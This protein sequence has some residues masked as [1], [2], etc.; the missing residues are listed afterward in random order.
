MRDSSTLSASERKIVV[1][2]VDIDMIIGT[3]KDID[4]R[5][6]LYPQI[7]PYCFRRMISSS[8]DWY[9]DIRSIR[10][11]PDFSSYDYI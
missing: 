10:S 4:N 3:K 2:D 5:E 1:T 8:D 11:Q 7:G 9:N 6:P